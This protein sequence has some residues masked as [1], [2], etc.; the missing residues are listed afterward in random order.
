MAFLMWLIKEI[1][2][3]D[4]TRFRFRATPERVERLL[5]DL[6]AERNKK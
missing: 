4:K 6:L 1:H 2:G 5:A 3:G